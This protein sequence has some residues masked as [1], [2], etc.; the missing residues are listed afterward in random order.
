VVSTP[1]KTGKGFRKSLSE[2]KSHRKALAEPPAKKPAASTK[3]DKEDPSTQSEN[4]VVVVHQ[5]PI[6]L[7]GTRNYAG[8]A[9]EEYLAT[10]RGY[11]AADIYDKMRRSESQV[12]MALSAVKNPIKK[13]VWE[14]E[15]VD[16]STEEQD[17]KE[18]VEHCLFCDLDKSWKEVLQEM[19]SMVDFG[20]APFEITDKAVIDHP[21]FGS[22][23]GIASLGWRSPRT[24]HRFNLDPKTGKLASISQYSFG[25]LYRTV[26][27]PAEFLM[28]FSIDKEGDAYEG[29]SGLR[30]CYGAYLRKQTYLKLQAIG[31]EKYAVP[32]PV[33]R[34]P[35]GKQ[36]TEQAE[37]FKAALE[38]Y[39]SHQANYITLPAGT[40]DDGGWGV[41]FHDTNF[42]PAKV[43]VA[44]ESEDRNMVKAFI[45]N[46]LE[47]GQ[48][49]SSGS[50]AL[51]FDQSDFFLSGIEHIADLICEKINKVVIERL[52]KLN[53][54]PRE[55]YPLLKWSGISD[56]AG[57][58]LAE[59]LKLLV[60]GKMVTPDDDLEDNLR[61]RY[62]LP[63]K[64]DKGQR[65][66]TP[67]LLPGQAP[68]ETP[69][70]S[71]P[72]G[73]PGEEDPKAVDPKEKDPKAK[74]KPAPE[75]KPALTEPSQIRIMLAEK[76]ISKNIQAAKE[77]L[78]PVMQEN[79]KA[80][81]EKMVA[82]IMR[83]WKDASDSAKI[84]A[85]KNVS[86]SAPGY[87]QA[88]LDTVT[89][90]A[91][92]AVQSARREV[93][94]AS[95]VQ[96]SG[97]NAEATIK[98]AASD[99]I[100][101]EDLPAAVQKLLKQ[102]SQLLVDTNLADLEKA[103][104]FRFQSSVG[105]TDSPSILESDL[106]EAVDDIVEWSGIETAAMNAASAIVNESRNAFFF[107]KEV[108]DSIESFTFT[109][110]DPVSLIC[111]DLAG[112]TFAAD[113]A[114]AARYFPP[115]HHN[116]KSYIVANPVDAKGN[117]KIDEN[118]LQPSSPDL[119][120]YVT[121]HEHC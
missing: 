8:Y 13:A 14:I 110:G 41:E 1:K 83:N 71:P 24:I 98:F 114:E 90:I 120:K 30:S 74:E 105:S 91:A 101:F 94:K 32:T 17:I 107:D 3:A 45:A 119:N 49:S 64:S 39:S 18:L 112:T 25:D 16:D 117:P 73:Q 103:V 67:P 111:Q 75:K 78:H 27:I 38:I 10:L 61:K 31:I 58:E 68:P 53:Y 44:I 48:S 43:Q 92:A 29:V 52:V 37:A 63:K 104:L 36:K 51:S 70:G 23:N 97:E 19:L 12:K 35:E 102:K 96:L 89:P 109:N 4:T 2:P 46:F 79:L 69:P 15:A 85:S 88:I 115:L 7:S 28:L 33:G 72:P 95:K 76:R 81:G 22:Y 66:P 86:A 5:A 82:K 65:L 26:E 21:L 106:N 55:K 56:D 50:W 100:A 87:N 59:T 57:K 40:G 34:I 108:L 118:G 6:G 93:P 99:E 84:N 113:D 42:D 60:D 54:G 116:C 20:F 80:A 62:K 11:Q 47:L 77:V 9:S 121:L